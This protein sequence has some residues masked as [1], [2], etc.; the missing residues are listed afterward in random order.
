M[1]STSVITIACA[2]AVALFFVHFGRQ[3]PGSP[4]SRIQHAI[5]ISILAAAAL[6][7][8]FR[9]NAECIR[10]DENHPASLR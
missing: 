6:L 4:T 7:N 3:A 1:I 10:L 8:M 2:F 5:V 9:P